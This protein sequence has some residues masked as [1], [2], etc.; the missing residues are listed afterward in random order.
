MKNDRLITQFIRYLEVERNA[1]RHTI[2]GYRAALYKFTE[3]IGGNDGWRTTDPRHFREF[4]SR[5]MQLEMSRSYI[6]SIFEALRSFYEY[7]VEREDF[8]DNPVE[9][10]PL[11]KL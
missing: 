6:R 5:C 3:F 4:L 8:A 9:E 1:S 10:V 7:L 2:I 11:P